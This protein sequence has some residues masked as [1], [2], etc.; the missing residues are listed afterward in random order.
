M[1]SSAHS[2]TQQINFLFNE[3]KYREIDIF[4]NS[5]I[6]INDVYQCKEET[7]AYKSLHVDHGIL[8]DNMNLP[9]AAEMAADFKKACL[10]RQY[11]EG[12]FLTHTNRIRI[13]EHKVKTETS[14]AADRSSTDLMICNETTEIVLYSS[15]LYI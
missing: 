3:L 5:P 6:Q 12:P 13:Y 9:Q 2:C 11:L 8:D 7:Y 4:I 14:V 1:T 15:I 10:T